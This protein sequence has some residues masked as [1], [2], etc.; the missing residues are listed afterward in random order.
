[1]GYLKTAEAMADR[2]EVRYPD[3]YTLGRDVTRSEYTDYAERLGCGVLW[4]YNDEV[5]TGLYAPSMQTFVGIQDYANDHI[6]DLHG[7]RLRE[8]SDMPNGYM[9]LKAGLDA[10]EEKFAF[11]HEVGHFLL[12]LEGYDGAVEESKERVELEM[13][14]DLV[15]TNV[16]LAPGSLS[17]ASSVIEIFGSLDELMEAR[18]VTEVALLVR[19]MR[20]GDMRRAIQLFDD[21]S[22]K[23]ITLGSILGC[24]D[25]RDSVS[26]PVDQVE[27]HGEY[28]GPRAFSLPVDRPRQLQLFCGVSKRE[29]AE[30]RA[31]MKDTWK[32][33]R[34]YQQDFHVPSV[35]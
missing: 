35:R 25:M 13:A 29:N 2:I 24:F 3:L 11:G 16:T 10:A 34:K 32:L 15:A 6:R 28:S 14:A 23:L 9:L 30:W 17:G 22:Y 8:V 27:V 20:D 19:A 1:M 21:E 7:E 4:I 5:P 33:I 26:D 18:N 12:M 31:Y